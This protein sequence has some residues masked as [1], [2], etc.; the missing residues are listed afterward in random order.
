MR[1]FSKKP[2]LISRVM[3]PK[4]EGE[5]WYV[6]VIQAV[7]DDIFLEQEIDLDCELCETTGFIYAENDN[8][9]GQVLSIH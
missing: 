3:C 9:Q 6:G 4:C 1:T 7:F 2:K 5:G 8:G